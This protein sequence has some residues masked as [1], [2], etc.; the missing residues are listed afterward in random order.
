MTE[1]DWLSSIDPQ[2]ML[3]FLRTGSKAS[4][5]KARLFAVAVCRLIWPLLD[6]ER[7]RRAVEVA[8]RYADGLFS[9]GERESA[10]DAA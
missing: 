6:D 2:V 5:R 1:A 10:S 7:S 9:E 4:Q 3:Y 8:E